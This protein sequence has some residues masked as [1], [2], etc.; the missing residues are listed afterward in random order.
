MGAPPAGIGDGDRHGDS[1]HAGLGG[2]VVSDHVSSYNYF[3]L[4]QQQLFAH[5]HRYKD[6]TIVWP[7]LQQACV[8]IRQMFVVT[9][10][11]VVELG[12]QRSERTPW[13]KTVGICHKCCQ[14]PMA[15]EPS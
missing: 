5:W 14:W 9:L 2:I 8:P 12:H 13:A 15:S 3:P 6:G 11:L 7:T 10:Q 4:E 1:V